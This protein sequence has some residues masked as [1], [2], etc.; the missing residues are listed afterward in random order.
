MKEEKAVAVLMA[1]LKGSKN[2]PSNLLTFAEATSTLLNNKNRWGLKE[3]SNYFGISQYMLRQIDKINKLDTKLQ[4]LIIKYDLG[5]EAAYHLWRI[6]ESEKRGLNDAIKV[7]KILKDMTSDEVR[8]LMHFFIKNENLSIEQ[9]KDLADK[10]NPEKITI[11]ALPLDKKTYDKLQ[12]DS[13]RLNLK[14]HEYIL[15]KISR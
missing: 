10:V 3:M 9:C 7:A 15:K 1:N 2:K 8:T 14:I 4:K 11:L 5:I 12:K 13:K 6:Q